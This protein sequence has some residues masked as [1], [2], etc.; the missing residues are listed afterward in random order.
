[1][2]RANASEKKNINLFYIDANKSYIHSKIHCAGHAK[3]FLRLINLMNSMQ[4]VNISF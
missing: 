3:F 2:S 1:M 4:K